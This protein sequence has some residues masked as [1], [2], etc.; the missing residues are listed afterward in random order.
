LSATTANAS[1]GRV[2][3]EE[4]QAV[5]DDPL[6][7]SRDVA[8]AI[9][10]GPGDDIRARSRNRNGVVVVP[11]PSRCRSCPS[12]PVVMGVTAPPLHEAE[13]MSSRGGG[14]GF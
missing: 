4:S 13:T 5:D 9:I 1:D 14:T 2:E 7:G 12:P 8:I 6:S 11:A 10:K 3:S